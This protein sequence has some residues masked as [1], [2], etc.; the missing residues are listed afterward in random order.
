MKKPDFYITGAPK[1]GT[2]AMCTYLREN[3]EIF[4]LEEKDS[5]F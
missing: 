2:T 3:P 1:C 4:M 5:H